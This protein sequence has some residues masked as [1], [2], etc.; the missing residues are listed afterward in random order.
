MRELVS[1]ACLACVLA[2][3][4]IYWHYRLP[5]PLAPTTPLAPKPRGHASDAWFDALLS[6]QLDG[7]AAS[8]YELAD[9]EAYDG[10]LSSYFSEANAM[11]TMQHLSEGIGYRVVGTQK[12]VDAEVWLED[13]LRRYEGTH[14]T[15]G[16]EYATHVE[17]FRQ[18]SDGRHR[19]EILGHPV[20]KRYYGM[21]NL[22]VRVSDGSEESK[23][24]TLLVNAHIDLSLIHI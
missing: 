7:G 22:I 19:F 10:P 13:V 12:H 5:T 14:A 23:A 15:G 4:S 21:S 20:W 9:G 1:L 16:S 6:H 18:Q 24:H 2:T 17:V 8:A 3:A 11:L